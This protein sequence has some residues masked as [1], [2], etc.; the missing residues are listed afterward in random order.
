MYAQ[1][2]LLCLVSFR[3]G[4]SGFVDICTKLPHAS[5]LSSSCMECRC[6][7]RTRRLRGGHCSTAFTPKRCAATKNDCRRSR[8]VV[9][10]RLP[11]NLSRQ[12]VRLN[13]WELMHGFIERRSPAST[14]EV[15]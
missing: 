15:D 11:S 7:V 8:I 14:H 3:C 2:L 6:H 4:R 1:I 9:L 5:A 13:L 12:A 10:S